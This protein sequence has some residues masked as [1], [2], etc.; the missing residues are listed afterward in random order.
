MPVLLAVLI[1]HGGEPGETGGLTRLLELIEKVNFRV[2]VAPGI[3]QRSD[4][5]QGWL[6]SIASNYHNKRTVHQLSA[7]DVS[8]AENSLDN[9]LERALVNFA[10]W[11]AKD[12]ALVKSL[13]LEEE[14]NYFDFYKWGGLK[15]FL[16]NYEASLKESK[17]I[18]FG[19]ILN[20]RSSMKSGDYF[21]VEHIW[22]TKHEEL[23][24]NTPRDS[25]IHR[26]LGNFMLL[27][28]DLNISGS[29]HDIQT[30]IAL[31]SGKPP[32]NL[33]ADEKLKQP[34][35]M[36]QVREL[37]ADTKR[38]LKDKDF[39]PSVFE[40]KR[41]RPY[42][43]LHER[44]CECRENRFAKFVVTQWSL[45]KYLGYKETLVEIARENE[46]IEMIG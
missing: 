19:Q 10:L 29:N 21:S 43:V 5:G 13:T 33:G 39:A 2:Y 36:A 18:K 26:R 42:R 20:A 24:Y 8:V 16:I 25:H 40:D 45:K 22:A 9:Q 44:I 4:T 27:E 3:T 7:D 23:V 38:V 30:K 46:K 37:I 41:Y 11:Y 35:E 17:T 31:Y 14:N 28:L 1:R 6:F 32:K 34:S 12:E 15:Y